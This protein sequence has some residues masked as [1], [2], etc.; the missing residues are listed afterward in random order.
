MMRVA[1]KVGGKGLSVMK[2]LVKV[3]QRER[4]AYR[5]TRRRS[6]RGLVW[7]PQLWRWAL[8]CLRWNRGFEG[9]LQEP[10]RVDDGDGGDDYLAV[11][12][13]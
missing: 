2:V 11:E 8:A 1:V 12:T 13:R 4:K 5:P 6:E 10:G 3:D 7:P 9:G